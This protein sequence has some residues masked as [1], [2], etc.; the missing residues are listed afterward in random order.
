MIIKPCFFA[1]VQPTHLSS[2]IL[3]SNT[4]KVGFMTLSGSLLLPCFSFLS[5]SFSSQNKVHMDLKILY[6]FSI[7]FS[8]LY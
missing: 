5:S 2:F 4:R 1:S 7:H 6:T 3:G 8:D